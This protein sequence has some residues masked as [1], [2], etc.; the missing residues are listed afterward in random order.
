MPTADA[1]FA[2]TAWEEQPY[3]EGADLPKMTRARVTKTLTGDIEGEGRVEYLMVYRADGTASFVGLERVTGRLGAK[4][5]SFVLQRTGVFENGEAKETYRVVA[6]SGTGDLR[7]LRGEG[8]SAVGHGMAH[9]FTLTYEL[10]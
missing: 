7:G 6:G 3:S 5:G 10:E 8:Q 1:R 9:P 2:I 4:T